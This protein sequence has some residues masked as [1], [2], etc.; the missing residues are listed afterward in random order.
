MVRFDMYN[1]TPIQRIVISLDEINVEAS[2]SA[3]ST[4]YYVECALE[5]YG[6]LV[7]DGDLA[8]IAQEI[9]KWRAGR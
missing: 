3:Y 9:S 4:F 8:V 2:A 7:N 1:Q 6:L 5:A